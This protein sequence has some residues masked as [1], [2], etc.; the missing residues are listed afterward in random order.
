MLSLT[1]SAAAEGIDRGA[2]LKNGKALQRRLLAPMDRRDRGHLRGLDFQHIEALLD[3]ITNG[4]PQGS[5]VDTRR[6]AIGQG[7]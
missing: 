3:L 2:L 1:E 5:L 6:L 4:P 7:V